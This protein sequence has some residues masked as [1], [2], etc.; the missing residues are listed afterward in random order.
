MILDIK[1]HIYLLLLID[2]LK[3]FDILYRF[4]YHS[5]IR[6]I[7]TIFTISRIHI[8]RLNICN[9]HI[10]YDDIYFWIVGKV[11]VVSVQ[12]FY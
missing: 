1:I 4:C 2:F 10:D 12:Q 6:S 9:K 7:N 3:V 11:G 8:I 5:Y